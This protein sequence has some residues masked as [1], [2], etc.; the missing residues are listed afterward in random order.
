MVLGIVFYTGVIVLI[1]WIL[2]EVWAIMQ[3]IN[4]PSDPYLRA[5]VWLVT[6]WKL[7]KHTCK[8]LKTKF[9]SLFS[10]SN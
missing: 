6:F 4:N 9:V 2:V 5:K 1:I 10:P 3:H 7:V 8:V